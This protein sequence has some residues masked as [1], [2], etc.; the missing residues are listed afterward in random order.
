MAVWLPVGDGFVGAD[1]I[2]WKEPAFRD[3]RGGKPV[4]VG[5][6][7]VTAEVDPE[8][9]TRVLIGNPAVPLLNGADHDEASETEN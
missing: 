5:E 1:V 8:N 9:G 6:R 3:R 2:R 7:L 4:H